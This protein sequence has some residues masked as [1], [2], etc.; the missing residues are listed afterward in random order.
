MALQELLTDFV[1]DDALVEELDR[2]PRTI[3][4]WSDQPD[5]LRSSGW[6]TGGCTTCPPCATGSWA[7]CASRIRVEQFA[8]TPLFRRLCES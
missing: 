4:R 3:K 2:H 1:E 7:G 5:G 8:P 6:E